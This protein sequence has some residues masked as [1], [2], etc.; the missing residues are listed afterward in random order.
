MDH[1]IPEDTRAEPHN[2]EICLLPLGDDRSGRTYLRSMQPSWPAMG[3]SRRLLEQVVPASSDMAQEAFFGSSQEERPTPQATTSSTLQR[4]AP[5][6]RLADH[7]I[8]GAHLHRTRLYCSLAQA[9]VVP[10]FVG[11][12]RCRIY[13]PIYRP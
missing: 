4:A 12:V 5:H 6:A 1:G 11:A 10:P 7:C 9:V 8:S 13:P 2:L 3:G